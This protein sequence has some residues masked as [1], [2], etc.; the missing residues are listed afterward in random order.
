MLELNQCKELILNQYKKDY[1]QIDNLSLLMKNS[2]WDEKGN[3]YNKF[4]S[5]N[6]IKSFLQDNQ[7]EIFHWSAW[8]VN[9]VEATQGNWNIISNI[10]SIW[11]IILLIIFIILLISIVKKLGKRIL[12]WWYAFFNHNRMIYMKVLLPRWDSKTDREQAKEIAKD[13]K[14]KNITYKLWTNYH[15]SNIKLTNT[16][17]C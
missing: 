8:E 6:N 4:W 17:A 13:M 15:P 5:I 14:E 16:T 3:C 11:N 12:R 7:Y 10:K 2:R 1:S 9:T